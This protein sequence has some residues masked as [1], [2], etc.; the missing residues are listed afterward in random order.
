MTEEEEFEFRLRYERETAQAKPTES[1]I[2]PKVAAH[3]ATRVGYGAA[4]AP[5][6]GAQLATEGLSAIPAAALPVPLQALKG[7]LTGADVMT[8]KKNVV[9]QTIKDKLRQF[10]QSKRTG[11][12]ERGE[13]PDSM[14]WWELGGMATTPFTLG[15]GAAIKAGNKWL[16]RMG[17]A[18]AEGAGYGA[19]MPVTDDD[20]FNTKV[21]QALMGGGIG[22]G[23]SGALSLGKY[24]AKLGSEVFDPLA[25]S[26]RFLRKNFGQY[27]PKVKAAHEG[28]Q[29]RLLGYKPT[30]A[31]ELS[32]QQRRAEAKGTADLYAKEPVQ[33]TKD[34]KRV[35]QKLDEAELQ[36]DIKMREQVTGE[37]ITKVQEA[38]MKAERAKQ[39]N[40]NYGKATGTIPFESNKGLVKNA[41]LEAENKAAKA[42]ASKASAL[43]D[44][45]RFTTLAD[46]QAT[47][48]TRTPPEVDPMLTQL[49]GNR[50]PTSVQMG[51]IPGQPRIPPRYTPQ[52]A[53]EKASR[54]AAKD[55]SGIARQ[56]LG[57]ENLHK[58]IGDIFA[59]NIKGAN[60]KSLLE[61]MKRPSVQAALK[62]VKEA[63]EE[64]PGKYGKW[65]KEGEQFTVAQLGRMKREIADTVRKEAEEGTVKATRESEILNTLDQF[66]DFLKAKSSAYRYA[67]EEF[68][69]ASIPI[70]RGK[71]S[72]ELEAKLFPE[73]RI[74][75][76]ATYIKAIDD[77]NFLRRLTK[78]RSK[79]IDD[80]FEPES[81]EK[82]RAVKEMLLDQWAAKRI[83]GVSKISEID[84]RITLEL[85]HILSRPVV[86]TNAILKHFGKDLTPDLHKNL[87]LIM[88]D[89]DKFIEVLEGPVESE[90]TK[91]A[92]DLVRRIGAMAAAQEAGE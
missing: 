90:A 87:E 43:Q 42:A 61:F 55:A 66:N 38:A 73:G 40:I 14:D 41:M 44:T 48:A 22:A 82:K 83:K 75:A 33:L 39:A 9:A 63:T 29:E 81:V 70:K 86:I 3:P 67:D 19:A 52:K 5:I 4:A 1:W 24:G 88:R 10:E 85:P 58:E 12:E 2:S 54:Q 25:T 64:A 79:S 45:G 65:P 92:V 30:V 49:T 62:G 17:A 72:R 68:A 23:A 8:G 53:V 37:K 46:Q 6:G 11:R 31:E 26:E 80:I 13:D 16:P 77:E 20:Y 71:V 91:S 50:A 60:T 47:R 27:L 7:V 76:G 78:D 56:R 57:E 69:K 89:T 21:V 32:Q 28:Y 34:L 35:G 36:A 59:Q 15:R 74:R 51:D 84:G 18:T